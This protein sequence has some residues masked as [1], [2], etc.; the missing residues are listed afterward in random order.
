MLQF[1]GG[2]LDGEADMARI[3]TQTEI[4]E[5]ITLCQIESQLVNGR[6]YFRVPPIQIAR[7]RQQEYF[8]LVFKNLQSFVNRTYCL[9]R[10]TIWLEEYWSSKNY[11]LLKEKIQI[12][13]LIYPYYLFSQLIMK[14]ILTISYKIQKYMLSKLSD[15][16]ATECLLK[17]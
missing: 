7:Q 8:N 4:D 3:L 5:N 11:I 15:L 2:V 9:Q 17:T 12:G 13:R 1:C 10:V 16:M 14:K 6:K